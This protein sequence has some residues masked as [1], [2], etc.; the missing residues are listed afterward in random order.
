M[1]YGTSGFRD[2][3]ENIIQISHKIGVIVSFLVST[4]N[5]NYGIMITA[6]HN[7]YFDNGVKIVNYNG[8]MISKDDEELIESYINDKVN[9]SF[10]PDIL[11]PKII[12]IGNDTRE[13]GFQIKNKIIEGIQSNSSVIIKDLN[14]VTTPQ[15]HY[16]VNKNSD[17][18]NDY[19]NKFKIISDLDLYLNN[20]VI[21]C[22]NGIGFNT[23]NSLNLNLNLINT[24]IDD[25][26]LLNFKSGSDYVIS[27]NIPPT[28]FNSEKIGCSLDGDA[29]RFIFYYFD[30]NGDFKILDG[31]YIGALYMYTII[32]Q[33]KFIDNEY[34][35]GYIH[36]PYTNS[37]LLKW[38]N[39][40]DDRIEIVC[41][42]TGV[43][44]LHHEALKYDISVYFE[45]NGHGTLLINNSELLD[46]YFFKTFNLINNNIVG[47]GISGMFCVMYCMLVLN[48][49]CNTWFNLFSKNKF[50]LY[51]KEVNN[52]NIFITNNIGNRLIKPKEIQ[53]KIDEINLKYNC[54]SFIRPSGTENVI[55]IYIEGNNIEE[56]KKE[57]NDILNI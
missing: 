46:N 23:L 47:D 19:V 37:A 31:D 52:K 11:S 53:N 54:I 55:R 24:K 9:I 41:A 4:K 21:D 40:L 2:K 33:L 50:M 17:N 27:D 16:L 38:L 6:S 8:E 15:H 18:V 10:P 1:K 29:D 49:N 13:S 22:A 56:I 12:Y 26:D 51:K 5:Q 3:A 57:I 30:I 42:A 39:E 48:I 14:H 35:I 28:N 20:I 32:K 43:K 25:F 34:S 45:S 36:S 44:N 7:L